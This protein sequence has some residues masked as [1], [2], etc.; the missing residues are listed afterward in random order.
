MMSLYNSQSNTYNADAVFLDA[1]VI[2]FAKHRIAMLYNKGYN[3]REISHVIIK[4]VI[5]AEAEFMLQ[6]VQRKNK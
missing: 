1:E 3:P 6:D 4:S 2:K 5:F